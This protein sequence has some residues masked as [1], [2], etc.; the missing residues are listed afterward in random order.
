MELFQAFPSN[1]QYKHL[2][3]FLSSFLA[4][5]PTDFLKGLLIA[6]PL[7]ATI[8]SFNATHWRH[9]C[10]TLWLSRFARDF[11]CW[12]LGG[13]EKLPKTAI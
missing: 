5:V 2:L 6:H 7:A 12:Y 9:Q 3:T 1:T 13:N 10:Y 4:A 8:P 11:I